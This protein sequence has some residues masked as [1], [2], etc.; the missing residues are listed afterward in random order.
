M[1]N[2]LNNLNTESPH[3]QRPVYPLPHKDRGSLL[4]SGECSSL[5]IEDIEV[6][7][8]KDSKTQQRNID[9]SRVT[10]DPRFNMNYARKLAISNL[11]EQ[12]V[13]QSVN[14]RLQV[15]NI[16]TRNLQFKAFAVKGFFHYL[17]DSKCQDVVLAPLS[18]RT[19]IQVS[20]ISDGVSACSHAHLG[21]ALLARYVQQAVYA[22]F[23]SL[24]SDSAEPFLSVERLAEIHVHVLSRLAQF[25]AT[26]GL[27][28]F[29]AQQ[30]FAATIQALVV[31]PEQEAFVFA[32]GD[33][34]WALN[35]KPAEIE[36]IVQRKENLRHGVPP[37]LY[38][39][40][41]FRS[42][43]DFEADK[44]N[45]LRST[46]LTCIRK[47]IEPGDQSKI[48]QKRSY[49]LESRSPY[50][51]WSGRPEELIGAS[52]SS[53]GVRFAA[54]ARI[55]NN[56]EHDFTFPLFT[57]LRALGDTPELVSALIVLFNIATMSDMIPFYQ[58]RF[59]TSVEAIYNAVLSATA[60]LLIAISDSASTDLL[61]FTHAIEQHLNFHRSYLN[62]ELE[63]IPDTT[64]K[65]LIAIRDANKDAAKSRKNGKISALIPIKGG[66]I[67]CIQTAA[68]DILR[69]KNLPYQGF[70]FMDDIS[71]V[72]TSDV[73]S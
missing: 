8:Q 20:I 7:I 63:A 47:F 57:L 4:Y 58:Q 50:L 37:L 23:D 61:P 70:H 27:D 19:D 1:A 68:K 25:I 56:D 43:D 44:R 17:D 45:S 65:I 16:Q 46:L 6:L 14:S 62:T 34:Y 9:T 28:L 48:E 3:N 72:Y 10:T 26:L 2:T 52:L 30:Y 15:E 53:D 22:A 66:L 24:V 73:S 35:S 11:R 51:V 32:L 18:E 60:D 12:F 39:A 69:S 59:N 21:A 31:I 71:I 38:T 40:L 55:L 5:S 41:L 67:A 36:A 49:A 13:Q 33:G 42:F 54:E 29:E 64:V